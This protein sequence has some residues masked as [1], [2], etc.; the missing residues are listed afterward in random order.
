VSATVAAAEGRGWGRREGT[1]VPQGVSWL[2]DERAY[3]FALYSKHAE[4]VTLLL[5]G[6]DDLERPALVRELDPLTQ[7]SSRVWHC[8]IPEAQIR[9]LRYY[10]Y[11]V[12]GPKPEGRT[13][14]HAFDPEKVLLDPY[15]RAIHFPPAFERGAATHPG[16]NAGRAPLGLLPKEYPPFHWGDDPR[17]WHEA[18]LVIYELHVGGFTRSP[19]S[20]V[21][22]AR[23][24]TFAGLVDRIP[25]LQDLGVSAV[26][27]MPVFQFDP[28]EGNFWGYMPVS[29]FAPHHAYASAAGEQRREFKELVRAL[30]EAGIEVIL[31]V[32]YNHTGEGGE[33]G[34]TYNLKGIDNSTYY[35]MT[36]D[37]VRPYADYSATGN[38]L[39]AA[40]AQVRKLILDSLRYWVEEMHVDG[41]RFDLASI[42]ARDGDG[43]VE[44]VDATLLDQIGADPVISGVRLIAEP[45]DADGHYTGRRFPA[46]HW[47]QW[48]DRFRD[49]VRRF[50]RGDAGLVATLM[51]RLYGSDD[52]FP[53]DRL[54]AFRPWQSVN[55]VTSHDGFTLYDLLSYEAKRNWAN[56]HANEDGP[57][58]SH[59]WNCGWEGD[60]GA[61]AEVLALRKRQAKNFCCLLLL[62]NGTPMIRAGDEFLQTQAGNDNPYNQ[63][64]PTSWLDWD[65]LDANRDVHRFFREMIAFRKAH[66]SLC[67]SR[68]W[69]EDVRW[70]GR[71]ASVDLAPGSR[72]L[73]YCLLGGSEADDDLYVMIN[74]S[75]ED[76]DFEVQEAGPWK[77]VIDTARPG[78]ADICA[79]RALVGSES[80]TYRVRGT[81]VAVLLRPRASFPR[82]GCPE[83]PDRR[84]PPGSRS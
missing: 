60:E 48:N 14:W 30:H 47:A 21:A 62:A 46:P 58:V 2:A 31:D 36:G 74:A 73:A 61:P 1:P 6:A 84:D 38:T 42:L 52:L 56:G 70:Y 22:E 34:P 5:Y 50:L 80:R 76:R 83:P 17:P 3:N 26:E 49:D 15:A 35:R 82:Q 10:A 41:F 59:S 65:R 13:E 68:F 66:P 43:A 9:P 55:H 57:S 16:P 12:S 51:T 27:L 37:P 18:D 53:G 67:R 19:S 20:G 7:K 78:G 81:S 71:G 39:H 63:D 54:H 29:F 64:N 44:S 40:N 24:G 23:R 77:R 79:P 28:Q 45:W 32:V 72:E 75:R 25:Y 33:T 11:R 69:R 4:T 8:R